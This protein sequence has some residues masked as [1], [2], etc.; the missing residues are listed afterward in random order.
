VELVQQALDLVL[1]L[2]Q[3]VEMVETQA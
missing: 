3:K 1:H 2:L